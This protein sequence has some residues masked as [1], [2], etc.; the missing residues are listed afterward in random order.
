VLQTILPANEHLG[1]RIFRV[2]LGLA[3]ISPLAVM[4]SSV[5][6]IV[7]AVVGAI[8]LTTGIIGSCPIYTMLGLSTKPTEAK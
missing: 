6:L 1:D 2:V 7:A 3:L 8:L 4:A 5:G